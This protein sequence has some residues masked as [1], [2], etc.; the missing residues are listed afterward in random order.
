MNPS[1]WQG[2]SHTDSVLLL[3][4]VRIPLKG[5][6][7]HGVHTRPCGP[8]IPGP[9][10]VDITVGNLPVL[11]DPV[12]QDETLSVWSTTTPTGLSET[13]TTAST[14]LPTLVGIVCAVLQVDLVRFNEDQ[15]LS[16]PA[17]SLQFGYRHRHRRHRRPAGV[18]N[19][20]LAIALVTLDTDS[21]SCRLGPRRHRRR[22]R[23]RR[24]TLR[25]SP[26]R[27]GVPRPTSL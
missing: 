12:G 5:S 26:P 9:I 25:N 8:H 11:I 4:C 18:A 23:E 10:P 6:G 1:L 16:E 13:L 21:I 22:Q 17:G 3:V 2:A 14:F 24:R 7:V 27:G 19:P 20:I 15:G